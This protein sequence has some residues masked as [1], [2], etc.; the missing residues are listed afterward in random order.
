MNYKLFL[1]DLRVPTDAY[2]QTDNN[3]WVIVR[4]LTDFK[5]VIDEKGFFDFVSFDHDLSDIDLYKDKENT[6]LTCAK[7]LIDYCFETSFNFPINSICS[8]KYFSYVP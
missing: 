5:K 6:G 1:D 7:F 8:R 2:P 4:N 3:S